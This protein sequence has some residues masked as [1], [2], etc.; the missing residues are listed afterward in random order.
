L[1][2][3]NKISSGYNASIAGPI[4]PLTTD[5]EIQHAKVAGCLENAVNQAPP[6]GPGLDLLAL[7]V[8]EVPVEFTTT[9]VDI[10]LCG[11][12]PSLTLPEVTADPEGSD[13]KGG[14]VSLEEV[15]CGTGI[16]DSAD[17]RNGSV[18]L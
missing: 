1:F 14:E 9:S 10:H 3:H 7:A 12:E 13:D 18:E 8:D 11:A 15:R 4:L 2:T 17:G 6:R 5:S 16:S